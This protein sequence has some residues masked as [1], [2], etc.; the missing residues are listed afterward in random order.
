MGAGCDIICPTKIFGAYPI[1]GKCLEKAFPLNAYQP[2]GIRSVAARMEEDLRTSP[3][4]QT[5]SP[6]SV[7]DLARR[8]QILREAGVRAYKDGPI[9]VVFG[10]PQRQG[11]SLAELAL[12]ER[13]SADAGR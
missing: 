5:C 1:C 9:E 6:T 10:A 2:S 7:D 11:L 12:A 3:E 8:V 4:S 13:A